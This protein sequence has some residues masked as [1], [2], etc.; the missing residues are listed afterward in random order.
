MTNYRD[1]DFSADPLFPV[2]YDANRPAAIIVD[3]DGTLAIRDGRTPYEW[4]RVM[5]DRPNWPVIVTVRNMHRAGY[6][7]IIVSGRPDKCLTETRDWLKL[8]LDLPFDMLLMRRSDDMARPDVEVKAEMY[9]KTIAARYRV[10]AVFDD[11]N[12]VVQMWRE[13]GLTVFQVAEGDF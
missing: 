1:P 5:E 7:V 13:L 4:S 11:R 8:H 10:L 3:V 6:R 2:P 9:Q 12:S